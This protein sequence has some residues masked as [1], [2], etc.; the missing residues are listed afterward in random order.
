MP[1][2]VQWWE[3][4]M[5]AVSV[6]RGPLSFSLSIGERWVKYGTNAAWPEWE[7][8]PTTPWNYG[9][10]LDSVDA[11][12][13]FTLEPR[14]PDPTAVPWSAASLPF[15]INATGRKI[16]GWQVDYR[17]LI[18][19][20]QK[21]PARTTAPEER[22]TLVPMGTA[23]LRITAFPTVTTD[24]RGVAWV[25]PQ[26][27][28]PIPFMISY[29]YINRYEDPEAVADGFEPKSSND[30]SITR[31]SWWDHK[32]TAEW[33]QYDFPADQSVSSTSVYWFDDGVDGFSRVPLSWQLLYKSGD[34]WLPVNAQTPYTTD[35]D[36]FNVVRFAPVKTR[37]LR[38]QVQLQKGYSSGVLEW[39]FAN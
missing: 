38:M 7:V 23:R 35:T 37:G 10:V 11:A 29:S 33:I 30:E 21:S 34:A 9:L 5:N 36:K 16:D 1:I 15:T 20:L 2:Q 25:P 32:G 39:K 22:L 14:T 26:K 28:K 12:R 4:N 6:N 13:S 31:M 3:K 24:A 17:N 19:P 8:F 18:G 27:P